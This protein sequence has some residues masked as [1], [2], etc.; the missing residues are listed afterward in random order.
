M[1]EYKKIG[2]CFLIYD[3]INH[4]EIWNLFFKN[5]DT[6]KY[7]IYIHYKAD[8]K[9]RY[10]EKYKLKNC[11]ETKYCDVSIVHAHN[12]L[13]RKALEDGC[14]K[15]I[16]LSQSCIPF[17][18]FDYIYNFLTKDDFGHFNITPQIQCFPRCE[19][20][21][22]YYDI[23]VIQKSSNWFILNRDLCKLVTNFDKLDI[24]KKYGDI[25]RPEEHYFIT[26]IFNENKQNNLIFTE[27]LSNNA[28]TF[29]NWQGMDYKYPSNNGLKNYNDISEE[30]LLYLLNSKCLFGRKFNKECDLDRIKY[31]DFLTN[32]LY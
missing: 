19:N 11:I 10:F 8:I 27:N 4:E 31:I 6:N 14:D 28:T 16:S 1:T 25:Y 32:K 29:T 17:K 23:N 5:I 12:L 13:F 30:E 9:L 20:L 7:K 2:F 21:L 18:S 3:I 22:K 15:I 26:T 24:N